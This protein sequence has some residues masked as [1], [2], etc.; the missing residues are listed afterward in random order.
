MRDFLFVRHGQSQANADGTIA[1]AST[2]LVEEG[3]E[4]ARKTGE[5]LKDRKIKV[6]ACS[7]YVRAQQTAEVIAGEF[8]IDIAQVR[9]IDEL[10]E[11]DLGEISGG[12]KTHPTEWYYTSNDG[13]EGMEPCEEL[14]ERMAKAL[15]KIDKLRRE[16]LVLVVGHGVSG[17]YLQQVAKGHKTVDE[18]DPP[19]QMNNAG[20]AHVSYKK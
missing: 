15:K 14:A 9:V 4:Q 20:V 16:G 12:P 10:R 2:P 8:G 7:P 19:S 17:F 13:D 5:E 3:L 1:T 6:I 11:R 18:F